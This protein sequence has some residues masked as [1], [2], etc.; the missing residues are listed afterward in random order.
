MPAS[1]QLFNDIITNSELL[2][3]IRQI[4]VKKSQGPNGIHGQYLITLGQYALERLLHIF[5]LSWK[6]SRLPRQWKTPII[7]FILK[8]NEDANCMK[9]YRPISHT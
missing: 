9:S 8:P 4:N 2:F 1:N 7:I 6:L 3:A 5:N